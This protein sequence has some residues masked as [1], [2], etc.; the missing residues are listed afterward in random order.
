MSEDNT[1]QDEVKTDSA[2]PEETKESPNAEVN[3]TPDKKALEKE[4]KEIITKMLRIQKEFMQLE[5]EKGVTE[6][7]IHHNPQGIVKE[8]K[9]EHEKLANRLVDIAHALKGS[10]RT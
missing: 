6:K 2:S 3:K 9:E 7:D 1:K 8:Y 5:R 4:R 10:I